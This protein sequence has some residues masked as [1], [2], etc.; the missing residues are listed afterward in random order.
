MPENFSTPRN[1]PLSNFRPLRYLWPP[2]LGE[3]VERHR[4]FLHK[5]GRGQKVFSTVIVEASSMVLGVE[6]AKGS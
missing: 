6:R 4:Y 2:D 1:L 3:D 5:L